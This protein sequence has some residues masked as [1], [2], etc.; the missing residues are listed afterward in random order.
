[1]KFIH[2]AD[3][4]WGMTPDPDMPWA[5]EREEEIRESFRHIVSLCKD[6]GADCLLIAGNLFHQQPLKRELSELDSLFRTIPKTHVVLLPGESD[7]ITKSSALLSFSFSDNVSCLLEPSGSFFFDEI[8]TEICALSCPEGSWEEAIRAF[9]RCRDESSRILLAS[10]SK[11]NP[12]PEDISFLS[13]LPFCYAALG[14]SERRREMGERRIVFPASPEPLSPRESGEHGVYL[15]ELDPGTG[16]LMKLRFLPIARRRYV[17]LQ[18]TVNQ[19]T[20]EEALLRL[21]SERMGEHGRERIYRIRIRGKRKPEQSFSLDSLRERFPIAELLD[22]SKP[23]YDLGALCRE[24]SSD[25]IGFYIRSFLMEDKEERSEEEEEALL[26][27]IRA[28]LFSE[29]EEEG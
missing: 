19:R 3:V 12:F 26:L 2:T 16:D 20:R 11:K 18:V 9:P 22:E 21:L 24:H 7:R 10:C 27:G 1:M 25:L 17:P 13:S 29:E 23:D 15:G 4:H 8:R 5:K 14:G 28:L 6:F